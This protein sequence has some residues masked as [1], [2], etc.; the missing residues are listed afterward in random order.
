MYSLLTMASRLSGVKQRCTH[1]PRFYPLADKTTPDKLDYRVEELRSE[2][3]I[4]RIGRDNP[5]YQGLRAKNKFLPVP[6]RQRRINPD[7]PSYRKQSE[8]E[9]AMQP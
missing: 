5:I 6:E 2:L 1:L 7:K 3:P 9:R 4:L 8:S